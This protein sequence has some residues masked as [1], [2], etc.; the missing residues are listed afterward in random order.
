MDSNEETKGGNQRTDIEVDKPH[1]SLF[2]TY[3]PGSCAVQGM[4]YKQLSFPALHCTWARRI[5]ATE[6]LVR[7]V[8][9]YICALI[10]S[11]CFFITLI[12][13]QRQ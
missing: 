11:L 13:V 10:P 12:S 7:F 8:D 5:G 3:S 6:G 1:Q 2:G 9:F 4:I